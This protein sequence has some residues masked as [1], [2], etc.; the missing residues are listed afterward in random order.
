MGKITLTHVFNNKIIVRFVKSSQ[1]HNKYPLDF[2]RPYQNKGDTDSENER[3]DG[4]MKY[5]SY[6][7][8]RS[9][10]T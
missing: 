3:K 10:R 2:G 6:P 1:I 5:D 8:L 7:E 9:F 4:K